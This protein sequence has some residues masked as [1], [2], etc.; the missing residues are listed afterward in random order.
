MISSGTAV[1]PSPDERFPSDPLSTV[2]AVGSA[3]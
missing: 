3:W 2:P 1:G